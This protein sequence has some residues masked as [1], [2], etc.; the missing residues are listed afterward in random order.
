LEAGAGNGGPRFT[1]DT[2]PPWSESSAPQLLGTQNVGPDWTYHSLGV[3]GMWTHP[4]AED[5]ILE[6]TPETSPTEV[7]RKMRVT[8]DVIYSRA[9]YVGALPLHGGLVVRDGV[10]VVLAGP[11]GVGKST[12]CKRIPPPWYS[13]CDDEVLLVKD[14]LGQIRAHPFPTFGNYS[15]GRSFQTWQTQESFLLKGIFFL[16]QADRDGAYSSGQ[17]EAAILVN[18]SVKEVFSQYTP[19]LSASDATRLRTL[20][21]DLACGVAREIPVFKLSVSPAGEFWVQIE[22]SLGLGE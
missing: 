16:D 20:V 6:L 2:S 9:I 13:P 18:G 22:R 5:I 14:S 19:Y 12:S 11:S 4:L 15:W 10:G 3:M 8:V 21:L 17:G 1:F 7:I